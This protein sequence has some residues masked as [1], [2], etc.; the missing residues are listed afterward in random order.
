MGVYSL[1]QTPL[2]PFDMLSDPGIVLPQGW[3]VESCVGGVSGLCIVEYTE[4]LSSEQKVGISDSLEVE[5]ML[6][7]DLNRV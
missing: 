1:P 3:E 5:Q 7:G 6:I 2:L 4:S